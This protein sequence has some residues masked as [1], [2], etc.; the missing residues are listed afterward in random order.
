M[1][2]GVEKMLMKKL[3]INHEQYGNLNAAVSWAS[4]AL[5]PFAAGILVDV[6][7]S[8][9]GTALF[10]IVTLLGHL[11]FTFAVANE[12]YEMALVGRAV[13][14]I[15]EST[16]MVAQGCVIAQWFRQGDN[17]GREL[18]LAIGLT[19]MTHNLSNW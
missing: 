12:S 18:A 4:L 1:T 7:A 11:V 17:G 15:G 9:V 8:R 2:S 13:F 14:G 5:I 3:D 19:E 6:R 16:V 10:A